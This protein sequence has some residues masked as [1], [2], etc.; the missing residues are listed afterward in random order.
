[1]ESQQSFG[2]P[3]VQQQRGSGNYIGGGGVIPSHQRT[4]F[5]NVVNG[6]S[7]LS[8]HNKDNNAPSTCS[9]NVGYSGPRT[10]HGIK[11]QEKSWLLPLSIWGLCRVFPIIKYL[12]YRHQ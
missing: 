10:G 5:D 1:M 9:S 6:L 12:M 3:F 8:S 4:S 11:S 7:S 2:V